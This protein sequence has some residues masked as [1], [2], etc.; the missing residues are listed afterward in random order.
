MPLIRPPPPVAMKIA[1]R[2]GQLAHEFDARSCPA[3]PPRADHC[4]AIRRCAPTHGRRRAPPVPRP[5]DR[6]PRY[7]SAHRA[8]V[9]SRACAGLTCA[10]KNTSASIPRNRAAVATPSPWLPVDEAM[11]PAAAADGSRL[12]SLLVAPR[13]LKEPLSCNCSSL[14][15]AEPAF[16][17]Q[18]IRAEGHQRGF[19]HQG[20]HPIRRFVDQRQ[21]FVG[22]HRGISPCKPHEAKVERLAIIAEISRRKPTRRQ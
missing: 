17:L 2:S 8:R 21:H 12:I 22:Q 9:S 10:L 18:F 5:A 1:S 6:R 13:S 7:E 3:P 11:T 19:P 16:E 4:R 14:A 15:K 20:V